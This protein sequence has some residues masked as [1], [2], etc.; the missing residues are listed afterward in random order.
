MLDDFLYTIYPFISVLV[1]AIL[2]ALC[3]TAACSILKV[4]EEHTGNFVARALKKLSFFG[5]CLGM[6]Q[7]L[8]LNKSTKYKSNTYIN[9]KYNLIIQASGFIP[10]V[11]ITLLYWFVYPKICSYQSAYTISVILKLTASTSLYQAIANIIP[12]PPTFMYNIIKVWLPKRIVKVLDD[13]ER[14]ILVVWFLLIAI[15]LIPMSKLMVQIN[16]LY[17][18]AFN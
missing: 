17:F 12:I 14:T 9:K 3:Q 10:F 8:T 16:T 4:S 2:A 11:V 7:G 15:F 5:I 6:V 18:G 13:N 1:C